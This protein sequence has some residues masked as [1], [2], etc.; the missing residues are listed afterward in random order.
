MSEILAKEAKY[1]H[2]LASDIR[3]NGMRDPLYFRVDG[4]GRFYLRDGHHR[5]LAAE[6]IGLNWLPFTVGGVNNVTS[7]THLVLV[8][9]QSFDWWLQKASRSSRFSSWL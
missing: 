1:V 6:I 4:A 7:D 2:E 5:V 9:D 8:P 3:E